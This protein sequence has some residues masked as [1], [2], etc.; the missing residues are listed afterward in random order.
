MSAGEM[1]R[2]GARELV[3]V[4]AQLFEQG[5]ATQHLVDWTRQHVAGQ[6]QYL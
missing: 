4:D 2:Q 1:L 3:I 6:I 5:Q